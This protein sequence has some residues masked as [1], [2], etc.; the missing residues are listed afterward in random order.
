M[1]ASVCDFMIDCLQNSIEARSSCISLEFVESDSDVSIRIID[2]GIG[3]TDKEI[4]KAVDPFY[5]D[6]SKHR[7]RRVGLG[8]P[9]MVQA[10]E[11]TG[12]N[13]IIESKKM[14]ELICFFLFL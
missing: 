8:L 11:Q 6:G 9:F 5:S 4:Q 12:G 7:Q 1:H 10:V 2:N 3:M 14:L 13:W